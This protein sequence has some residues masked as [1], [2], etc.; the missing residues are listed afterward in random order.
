MRQWGQTHYLAQVLLLPR[1]GGC[2]AILLTN[3]YYMTLTLVTL[4]LWSVEGILYLQTACT[5]RQY[6]IFLLC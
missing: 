4:F 5:T 6:N 2:T 1:P 3:A